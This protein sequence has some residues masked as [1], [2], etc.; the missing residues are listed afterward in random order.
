MKIVYAALDED[1]DGFQALRDITHILIDAMLTHEVLEI[2][3]LSHVVFNEKTQR[4]ENEQ[5]HVTLMST[6]IYKKGGRFFN[7]TRLLKNEF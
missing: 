1:G 5:L 6:T 2:S 3:D 7:G 4:F